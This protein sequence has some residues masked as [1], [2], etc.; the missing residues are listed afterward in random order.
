MRAAGWFQHR[1]MQANLLKKPIMI[2]QEEENTEKRV[3]LK[4]RFLIGGLHFGIHSRFRDNGS[5]NINCVRFD[6]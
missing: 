3:K 1:M 6:I 4:E 5:D 2:I